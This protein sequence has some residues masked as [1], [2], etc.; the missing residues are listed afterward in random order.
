M[1]NGNMKFLG[2][3]LHK[4]VLL[5]VLLFWTTVARAEG[6]VSFE[7]NTPMLVTQGEYFNV[8][9]ILNNA[10]PDNGSFEAPSFE[11]LDVLA[12]PSISNGSQTYNINGVKS[13]TT[14]YTLTYTVVA[15]KTGNITI[16]SAKVK[17][18]GKNY[19][20]KVTP[21]EVVAS[22]QE[23]NASSHGSSVQKQLAQDDIVVRLNLSR[24]SVYRGEPIRASLMLYTRANIVGLQN[25][26][27]PSFNGFWSQ[28]L[29]TQP[30]SSSRV[31]L[32]DKVYEAIVMKDYLL[33]PQ[34]SGEIIIEPATMT[35]VAQIEVQSSRY[36]PFFGRGFDTYEVPRNLST[37]EIKLNIKELPEGA[38]ASFDG[39][40]GEFTLT[41]T[42]PTSPIKA[43]SATTYVAK[44][45]GNGNMNFLQ[46]PVLTLPSSFEL[47]DVKKSEQI[48]ATSSGVSGW[49]Q[50]EYPII[51]RSEG[52]YN[53]DGV[54][55]SYF[56]PKTEQY[57]TLTGKPIEL[58]ILPDEKS[59]ISTPNITNAPMQ[60]DVVQ[61]GTDIRF[62]K[63]GEPE[64][65]KSGDAFMMSRSYYIYLCIIVSLTAMIYVIERKRI[66]N[67]RNLVL[68]RNRRANKV[69]IQRF[70]VAS[71][72]MKS[73]NRH[74]FF[75]EML[76]AL[77]GYISD[78]LNIPVSDLSKMNIREE[79]KNHG[80]SEQGVDDFIRIIGQCEEAQYSP[81]ESMQMNKVY[82]DGVNI[83][84]HIESV[85]K[86]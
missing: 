25:F 43:N 52:E 23:S 69:A 35:V 27:E 28:E 10:T 54:E 59:S 40:V 70:Q 7:V 36:D 77:W 51:A 84:S 78:K 83:I 45:A 57:V 75:S 81:V 4:T 64:L 55:F 34:K 11:G 6:E 26:K 63:L 38:P 68:V 50:F 53:V 49:K 72:H 18:N 37:G 62:I 74:E 46:P 82:A 24:T 17:V 73:G 14:T 9:F 2:R 30:T 85:I 19:S 67:N 5:V 22:Q 32:N 58:N 21:L 86:R 3:E 41:T 60:E 47:Y 20:T 12:G 42:P 71:K 48:K 8:S 79:L 13:R 15:N 66:K 29:Q 44:I 76:K 1:V 31:T 56:N 16:G 39:A 65:Q 61:L 80:V 33:Y